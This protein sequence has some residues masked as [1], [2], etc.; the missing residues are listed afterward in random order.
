MHK[1]LRGFKLPKHKSEGPK[2]CQ[3]KCL[4]GKSDILKKFIVEGVTF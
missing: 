3:A 2:Q 1:N 4:R